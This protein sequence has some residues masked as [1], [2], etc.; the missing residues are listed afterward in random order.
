[1]WRGGGEVYCL[2]IP[3]FCTPWPS[4]AIRNTGEWHSAAQAAQLSVCVQSA[5]AKQG[6]K[7]SF[8]SRRKGFVCTP[9]ARP[10]AVL[11]RGPQNHL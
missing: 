9:A 4:S 8:L 2:H 3:P 7:C 5:H 1:M 6:S 10:T 11:A